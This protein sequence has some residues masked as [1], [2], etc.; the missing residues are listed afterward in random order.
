MSS[1]KHFDATQISI[2][3]Y[4]ASLL[5]FTDLKLEI[6]GDWIKKKWGRLSK[7]FIALNFLGIKYADDL[8]RPL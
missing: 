2:S 8:F 1:N 3:Q 5:D 6:T 7:T 4:L